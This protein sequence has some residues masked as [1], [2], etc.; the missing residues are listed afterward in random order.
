M[1][2]LMMSQKKGRS[3]YEINPPILPSQAQ[4]FP[5]DIAD[6]VLYA[7]GRYGVQKTKQLLFLWQAKYK[8]SIIHYVSQQESQNG[9]MCSHS[10]E[11]TLD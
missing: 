2:V 4:L 5:S 8:Q 1:L 3:A 6:T 11:L 7:I 10:W 9:I